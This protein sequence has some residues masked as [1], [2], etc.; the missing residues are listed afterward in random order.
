MRRPHVYERSV[1][2]IRRGACAV[3]EGDPV[4]AARSVLRALQAVIATAD[5]AGLVRLV[6]LLDAA[7]REAE[8]VEAGMPP[9]GP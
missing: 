3:P 7:R 6:D 9:V 1:P 2:R 8:R 5:V 4:K